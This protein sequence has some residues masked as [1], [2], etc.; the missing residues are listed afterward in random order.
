MQPEIKS[1]SIVTYC[2]IKLS[3]FHFEWSLT[4]AWF[5]TIDHLKHVGLL[6]YAILSHIN[7]FY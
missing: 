2:Y 3:T 7:I 4:L 6:H 1:M 5:S